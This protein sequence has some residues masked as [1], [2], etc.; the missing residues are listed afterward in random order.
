MRCPIRLKGHVKEVSVGVVS[1]FSPITVYKI[2]VYYRVNV[3]SEVN[4]YR[5][6]ISRYLITVN[7]PRISFVLLAVKTIDKYGTIA[8]QSFFATFKG[9]DLVI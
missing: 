5:F 7:H 4:H 2:S 6:D 1:S 3:K 9:I 8:V